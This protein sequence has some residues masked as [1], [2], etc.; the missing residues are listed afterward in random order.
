MIIE[1]MQPPQKKKPGPQ[2]D[3]AHEF[4]LRETKMGCAAASDVYLF[5]FVF[6]LF[7][8]V[9]EFALRQVKLESTQVVSLGS[10]VAPRTVICVSGM[11]VCYIYTCLLY[12]SSICI[13]MYT[14]VYIYIY[15]YMLCCVSVYVLSCGVVSFV[16]GCRVCL[17]VCL[18][19]VGM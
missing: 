19:V 2:V 5:V 12:I 16:V 3:G 13:H 6:L 7:A 4:S 1:N 14:Y 8:Q 10:S 15:I 9:P 11:S 18:W 17:S